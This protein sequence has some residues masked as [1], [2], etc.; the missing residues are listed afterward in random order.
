MRVAEPPVE[1]LTCQRIVGAA[2]RHF[3]AHGFRTVTMDDLAEEL[4]MSKKTLYAHFPSKTA[5]VEAV[6]LD[7]LGDMETEMERITAECSSDFL[8]A[9]RQL[10]AAVQRGTEEIQPVFL[11][12][13]RRETPELFKLVES[14][15]PTLIQR[16]FGKLFTAGRNAGMIRRD[17][18]VRLII[19][20]LISATQGIMN[21]Q[22]LAELGIA[23][24][25]GSSAI[26]SVILNGA[27]TAAG[28]SKL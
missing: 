14:R 4:G 18:P 15:R 12:D 20:V 27:L 8:E 28:R 26:I 23:P 21:P 19:E 3:F 9:L 22:K 1:S 5:L 6:L 2:R 11:R 13:I 25:V 24:K 17:I 16:H 7:K 10:L